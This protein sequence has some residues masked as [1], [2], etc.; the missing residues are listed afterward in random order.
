MESG[1]ALVPRAVTVASSTARSS[2]PRVAFGLLLVATL[3]ACGPKQS[4]GPAIGVSTKAGDPLPSPDKATFYAFDPLDERPVSSQAHRG[5]PT[6]IVF[7]TTG[8]IV[9]QAQVSYLVHM[10]KNDGDRVNYALVALHPRKEIVLVE[11]YS[12]T[13]GVDFPVALADHSATSAAG[14]FGE[15]PAVPTIV[16]LDRDGRIAWKHTGLA[17]NDDIRGHMRGL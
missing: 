2:A 16:V 14:P 6:V 5:K 1:R 11:S 13:L 4:E 8:D 10:A 7:V 15:I 3:A 17:K 9:G 12:K